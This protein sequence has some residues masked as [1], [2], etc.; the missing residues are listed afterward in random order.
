MFGFQF[1]DEELYI[2]ANSRKGLYSQC[3][4][5]VIN[6]ILSQ[7]AWNEECKG[8]SRFGTLPILS[9]K[10]DIDLQLIALDT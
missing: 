10:S 8:E 2:V 6:Y 3:N 9:I 1:D 4:R 5:D 7:S